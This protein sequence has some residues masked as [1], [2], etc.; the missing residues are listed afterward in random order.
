MIF[1][2]EAVDLDAVKDE[3]LALEKQRPE[4]EAS[5]E[6]VVSSLMRCRRPG[7]SRA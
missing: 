4:G 6:T 1:G 2:I 7:K 3:R 5:S